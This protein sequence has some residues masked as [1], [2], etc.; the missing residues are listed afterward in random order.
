MARFFVTWFNPASGKWEGINANDAD[1]AFDAADG[2]G[3]NSQ[4]ALLS[5][6][7]GKFAAFWVDGAGVA[8][9]TTTCADANSNLLYTA[10]GGGTMGNT[11]TVAYVVS[12]NNT[13]LSVSVT[14]R[15]ITVNVAT[16]AGGAATSTGNAV[17]AA[18]NAHAT[19]NTL[20]TASLAP[21]NDGTGIVAAFGATALSGGTSGA[22]RVE[23]ITQTL[24]TSATPT[25]F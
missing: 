21:S 20:V 10:N 1:Q 3:A 9:L 15:A 17:L 6:K 11:V 5:G 22:S 19:A 24:T 12:G 4:A 8:T 16:S 18:V 13:P 25:T 7:T 23:N 2:T 14:G